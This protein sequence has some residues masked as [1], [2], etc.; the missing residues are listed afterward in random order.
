MGMLAEIY[1]HYIWY[2]LMLKLKSNFVLCLCSLFA[3]VFLQLLAVEFFPADA[4][5]EPTVHLQLERAK[6]DVHQA[7]Y[8]RAY[9]QFRNLAHRGQVPAQ[10]VSG[11]M[12]EKG[13]GTPK[14]LKKA[15]SYYKLAAENDFA[16]SQSKLGHMYL[17]GNA[18]VKKDYDKAKLWLEKAANNNV[19]EA[20]HSLGMMYANGQGVKPDIALAEQWLKRAAA[21]GFTKAESA[22]ANLPQ[23]HALGSPAGGGNAL[24]S[25]GAAYGSELQSIKQSWS[26][27]GDVINTLND[28]HQ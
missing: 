13:C 16:E 20:Q 9:S 2:H 10:H 5:E 25:A 7:H 18:V 8:R 12:C 4:A 15:V 1:C 22:L 23:L 19:P 26:G 28:L 21:N 27:Y 14:N 17:V 6:E 24:G 3:C 11:L